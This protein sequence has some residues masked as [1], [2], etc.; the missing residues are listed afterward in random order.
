MRSQC[1][2]GLQNKTTQCHNT[3]REHCLYKVGKKTCIARRTDYLVA[4]KTK[5]A[6]QAIPTPNG[7][8]V[9]QEEFESQPNTMI[10]KKTGCINVGRLSGFNCY[11]QQVAMSMAAS[12]SFDH[13]DSTTVTSCNFPSI[14]L[15]D[16]P[17][18]LQGCQGQWRSHGSLSDPT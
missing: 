1:T 4:S 6:S 11:K 12:L 9:H 8:T 3:P 17:L 16:S 2:R 18:D 5:S 15:C 14:K 10:D 13:A 7:M